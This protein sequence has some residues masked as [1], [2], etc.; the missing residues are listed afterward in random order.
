MNSRTPSRSALRYLLLALIV[1]L[2]PAL[3][4]DDNALSIIAPAEAG[5][6]QEGLDKLKILLEETKTRA[7]MV[8]RDGKVIAEWYWLDADESSTFECWSTSK[9]Y[10]STCIGLL[11]DDGKIKSIDDPVSKYVPS[12][13]EGDKAKITIA[14]LLDQ[15][16]GLEEKPGF[17]MAPNQI[18]MALNAAIITPPG[19]V[20]RYNN[21]GCNVLSAIISAAAGEDPEAYMKKRMWEPMGMTSTSW[22]RDRAGHVITY[23]GVQSNARDLLKFGLVHLNGGKWKGKQ[24]LSKEWVEL[25]TNERTRLT[26]PNMMPEGHPYGLLWWLDFGEDAGVP[27]SYSSLGLYGNNM[28]VIPEHKIVGVRLVGNNRDGAG[29]MRRTGEWVAALAALVEEPVGAA[30]K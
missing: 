3:R 7:A 23:A 14:H 30:A 18:E 16:S 27:H 11:I 2:S 12:W 17:P 9:S 25:A 26:I 10:A 4:A 6:S 1:C 24:I 22:R 19:E 5:I 28:T 13:S 29:L 15:T 20:G 8:A 21:A